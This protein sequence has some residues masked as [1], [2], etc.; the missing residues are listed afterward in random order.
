MALRLG[1]LLIQHQIITEDQLED[2]LRIQSQVGVGRLGFHLV[3][4]GFVDETSLSKFLGKHFGLPFIDL[5]KGEIP[6]SVI[7]LIPKDIVVKY[8]TI[9]VKLTGRTLTVVIDNPNDEKALTELKQ[10][11]QMDAVKPIVAAESAIKKAIDRYY[12][13]A[14]S[15]AD[16]MSLVGEETPAEVEEPLEDTEDATSVLEKLIAAIE[17]DDRASIEAMTRRGK[18][19]L[20]R[21]KK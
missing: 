18:T 8:Q 5:S 21:L 17:C 14:D 11:A 4:M 10:I 15:L 13:N 3:R 7:D 1:E 20:A 6:Q 12:D 9:P 19:V 2:A 16:L